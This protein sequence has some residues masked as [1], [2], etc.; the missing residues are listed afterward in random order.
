MFIYFY[1]F[2]LFLLKVC[3]KASSISVSLHAACELNTLCFLFY[4]HALPLSV[5]RP[6][7]VIIVFVMATIIPICPGKPFLYIPDYCIPK[8]HHYCTAVTKSN[9]TA[10]I[11]PR[12]KIF[13]MNHHQQKHIILKTCLILFF[14][15]SLAFIIS[16]ESKLKSSSNTNQFTLVFDLIL[17]LCSCLFLLYSYEDNKQFIK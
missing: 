9:V 10:D 7:P 3:L 16:L 14:L 1:L 12:P 17:P 15:N 13:V 11:V 4:C 8:Q 6:T 2:F 5:P